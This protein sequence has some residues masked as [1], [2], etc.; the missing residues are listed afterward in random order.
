MKVD[1]YHFDC[2]LYSSYL[3]TVINENKTVDRQFVFGKVKK[4]NLNR[5]DKDRR[6]FTSL[7]RKIITTSGDMFFICTLNT[8]YK[9]DSLTEIFIPFEQLS[10]FKYLVIFHNTSPLYFNEHI[11]DFIEPITRH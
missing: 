10:A 3:I 5:F 1:K 2:E 6:I 4:D 7:I 9:V 8:V 11:E